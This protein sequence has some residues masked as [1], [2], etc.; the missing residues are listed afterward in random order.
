MQTYYLKTNNKYIIIVA[1][2]HKKRRFY[3]INTML[4]HKNVIILKGLTDAEFKKYLK[5]VIDVTSQ[6][7]QRTAP[8]LGVVLQTK[9]I[10][11]N[12][13]LMSL[14]SVLLTA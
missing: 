9:M 6:G 3:S 8:V 11:L 7:N 2:Y 13:C 5:M 12:H 14:G 1:L 4:Q 10:Y